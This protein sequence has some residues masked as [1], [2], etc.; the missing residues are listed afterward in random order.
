MKFETLFRD[1]IN[2][3]MRI[4]LYILASIIMLIIIFQL[5]KLLFEL[6]DILFEFV[7]TDESS[8]K[9][10]VS[11]LNLFILIEFFRGI[12]SYFEFDRLKLS[13]IT[14]AVLVFVL[15]EIMITLFYKHMNLN[16][17]ISYSVIIL[18]LV[19]LRTLS[20]IYTPDKEKKITSNR[21]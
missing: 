12:L 16:L 6:K 2:N 21:G 3:T 15:R 14:D 10:V 7:K 4:I 1:T 19:V 9:A 8:K 17:S 18:A 13:Y 20:I 11:V 5:L